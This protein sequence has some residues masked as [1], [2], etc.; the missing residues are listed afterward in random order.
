[1]LTTVGFSD[2]VRRH[3]HGVLALEW[4]DHGRAPEVLRAL[5]QATRSAIRVTDL[6][7]RQDERQLIVLVPDCDTGTGAALVERVS[8]MLETALARAIVPRLGF[9]CAPAD[10]DTLSELIQAAQSRLRRQRPVTPLA[11]VR[12]PEPDSPGSRAIPA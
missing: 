3:S 12:P 4:D 11:V 9:A 2:S 6:M 7:F 5:A 8:A 1:V 10:G